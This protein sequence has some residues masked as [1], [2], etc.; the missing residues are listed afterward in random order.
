MCIRDRLPGVLWAYRT[1]KRV[2]T[3]ETLF[4]LYLQDE[5]YHFD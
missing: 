5:G 3:G 1:N 2:L 4:S